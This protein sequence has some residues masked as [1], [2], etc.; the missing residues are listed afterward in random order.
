MVFVPVLCRANTRFTY[1]WTPHFTVLPSTSQNLKRRI[2]TRE[3]LE[4]EVK[5]WVK[6]RNKA[7]V[8]IKWQFTVN[9]ARDS[10]YAP[11]TAAW[12]LPQTPRV[13]LLETGKHC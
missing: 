11:P 2:G 7:K 4:T 12:F 1:G 9:D 8:K 3:K 13:P 10:D 6:A 5:A